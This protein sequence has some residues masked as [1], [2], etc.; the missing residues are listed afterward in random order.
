MSNWNLEQRFCV[1]L[2]KS[3]TEICGML[4]EAYGTEAMKKSSVFE[5]CNKLK[6]G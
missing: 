4:S 6:E 3:A 2:G 5:W 1:K